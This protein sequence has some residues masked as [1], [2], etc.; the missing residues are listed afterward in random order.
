MNNL[1]TSTEEVEED[2]SIDA[3]TIDAVS[4]ASTVDSSIEQRVNPKLMLRRSFL[5]RGRK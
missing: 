2:T 1:I 3:S 5:D 4:N